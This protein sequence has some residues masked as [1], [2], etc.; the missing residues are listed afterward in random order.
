MLLDIYLLCHLPWNILPLLVVMQSPIHCLVGVV[1]WWYWE[2]FSWVSSRAYPLAC[3]YLFL[4]WSSFYLLPMV[5]SIG[6]QWQW[7]VGFSCYPKWDL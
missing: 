2:M 7:P 1:G 6:W 4:Q 3:V 5:N